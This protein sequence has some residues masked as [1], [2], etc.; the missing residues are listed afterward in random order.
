MAVG[1]NRNFVSAL[2]VPNFQNLSEWCTKHGVPAKSPDEMV[3]DPEIRKLFLDAINEKNKNFGQ[4][5]TVKKFELLPKEWSI[6][7]GELTPTMKVKRKV[8]NEKFKELIDHI[9]TS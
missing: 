7:G 3:K 1:E 5:E 8:V 9:Y 6:E 2:I 4:W